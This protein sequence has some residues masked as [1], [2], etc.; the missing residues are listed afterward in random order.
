[1]NIRE[2]QLMSGTRDDKGGESVDKARQG[3]E[4]AEAGDM[5]GVDKIDE[6]QKADPVGVEA[7]EQEAADGPPGRGLSR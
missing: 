5:A 6:A 3:V 4:Q 2:A 7:V 1:L